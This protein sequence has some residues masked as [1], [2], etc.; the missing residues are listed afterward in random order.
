MVYNSL[1]ASVLGRSPK[2]LDAPPPS[3]KHTVL[4]LTVTTQ[5]ADMV[6]IELDMQ[7]EEDYLA[8]ERG[9]LGGERAKHF[10]LF[11]L[12]VCLVDFVI[13]DQQPTSPLVRVKCGKDGTVTAIE[14]E[15]LSTIV[16]K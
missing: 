13:R 1:V 9:G 11:C 5:A 7:N 6:R 15:K 14:R 2:E 3:S 8:C 16:K 4:V 10:C 12:F